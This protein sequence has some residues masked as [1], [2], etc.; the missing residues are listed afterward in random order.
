MKKTAFIT[1]M[2]LGASTFALPAVAQTT[3]PPVVPGSET[4]IEEENAAERDA[5]AAE[6][7]S[8]T[9]APSASP[10]Q[11]TIVPGSETGTD[12]NEADVREGVAEGTN[13]DTTGAAS[14]GTAPLVPGSGATFSPGQS[15]AS[16]GGEA[17]QD[18]ADTE[19][20]Q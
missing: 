20:T 7:G 9:D 18:E 1:A 12:L 14:T 16:Q 10:T 17:L 2:L 11:D 15:P 4:V 13:A 6:P 19:A 5:V 8:A 3:T